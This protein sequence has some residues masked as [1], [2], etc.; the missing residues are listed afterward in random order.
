MLTFAQVLE[1]ANEIITLKDG[2][3]Y[4]I[5]NIKKELI[6]LCS[7][8]YTSPSLARGSDAPLDELMKKNIWIIL[9]FENPIDFARENCDTMIFAIKPKYD[10]LMIYKKLED[11]ICDKV[12]MINLSSKTDNLI[13]F[14]ESNIEI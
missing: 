12:P 2:K 3:E 4:K 1:K 6:N 13:K 8:S 9:K 11:N 7:T 5:N 10:F 14:I